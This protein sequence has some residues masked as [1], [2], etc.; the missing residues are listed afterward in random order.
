MNIIQ[1]EVKNILKNKV[2]FIIMGMLFIIVLLPS[3]LNRSEPFPKIAQLQMALENNQTVIDNLK[4]TPEAASTVMDLQEANSYLESFISALELENDAKALEYEYKYEL[5][6]LED[7]KAGKL[8]GQPIIEQEKVVAELEFLYLNNKNKMNENSLHTL[9]LSNYLRVIFSG[10]VSSML[11]LIPLSL[12]ISNIVSY[13]KRKNKT[14]LINLFPN[15][16][17]NTALK[18]YVVYLGF[19][20]FSFIFP[21]AIVSIIVTIKNGL[22]DFSYPIAYISQNSF[23]DIMPISIFIVKNIVMLLL[24]VTLLTSISFL[25]SLLTKNALLNSVILLGIIFLSQYGM[26]NTTALESA[27][28]YLPTS[29]VDFQNVILGGH[30][31][32]PLASN[33]IN[34]ENGTLTLIGFSFTFIFLSFLRLSLKKRF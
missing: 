29:Y 34:F 30:G 9:P 22:G 6:N 2:N 7:M 1:F 16:L 18:R 13:E 25:I 14:D 3:F 26:L 20:L 10:V 15:S 33:N 32:L 4:D 24:W 28:G 8:I 5:K 12:L 17:F 21:L 11:F 23:V 31:Y 19:T 27:L